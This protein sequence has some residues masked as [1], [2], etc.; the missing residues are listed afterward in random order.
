MN[1]QLL[2]KLN[3][4]Y[5]YANVGFYID[6]IF[7]NELYKIAYS[8]YVQDYDCN[9]VIDIN[10]SKEF[11][12]EEIEN[13]MKELNRKPCYIVTPLSEFYKDRTTHFNKDKYEEVHNEVW[14]IFDD[15][16]N[17]EKINP[18]FSLNISLEKTDDMKKIA[19][20]NYEAFSTDNPDDPYGNLD[21]SYLEVYK[22]YIEDKNSKYKRDFYFIKLD[23]QIVGCTV[24]VYDE[25]IYGIYGIAIMKEYR[26]KGIGKEALKQQLQ[27]CKDKNIKM[28]F[29]QTEDGFYPAKLYRKIGFKDV[30]NVYYYAL[31]D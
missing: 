17:I 30:C 27:I 7:D 25:E 6:K 19:Q 16:D 1:N 22:N 26:G 24:G 29:L 31:K 23:N 14:Q 11:N 13:K 18:N 20:I 3:E 8:K 9:Y 4:F 2:E 15:F 12:K 21:S 10:L 5:I 28:A